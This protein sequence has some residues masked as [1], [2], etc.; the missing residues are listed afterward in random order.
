MPEHI[1]GK[2]DIRKHPANI[3]PIGSGA[4]KV[5]EFKA[6]KHFILER[7]DNYMRPGQP[8]IDRYIGS[9]VTNPKAA[10]MAMSNGQAHYFGFMAVPQM[11]AGFKANEN[12]NVTSEGYEGLGQVNFLEFNL[13]NKYFSDKRV[14]KAIA[15]AIDRDFIIQ[16]L[17]RGG[18]R[19]CTGPIYSKHVFYSDQVEHYNLNL[20]KANALLDEG[21]L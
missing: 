6:G 18:S 5:T 19:P 10:Y 12:L 21:G 4:F 8:Y 2:G 14:R 20:D 11:M 16:K 7:N 1:Y 13:R 3:K 9:L 15:Y 17:H